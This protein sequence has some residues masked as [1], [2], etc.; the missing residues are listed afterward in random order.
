MPQSILTRR[1]EQFSP[2]ADLD[3]SQW[4]H[5]DNI[6]DSDPGTF[7]TSR[8]DL[9]ERYNKAAAA[10]GLQLANRQKQ[11]SIDLRDPT[12]QRINEAGD[13]NFDNGLLTSGTK[14]PLDDYATKVAAMRKF[15]LARAEGQAK[16]ANDE[17]AVFSPTHDRLRREHEEDLGTG[18][19]GKIQ[20]A[21]ARGA[22]KSDL[23]A[24]SRQMSEQAND[25]LPGID[26][27][28]KLGQELHD[29]GIFTPGIG[30]LRQAFA[31]HG[32]GSLMGMGPDVAGKIGNFNSEM[33]L[34]ISAIQR[35][36]AGARGAGN[37]AMAKR[38]EELLN[39]QGDIPTFLG[40]LGGAKNWMQQY[41]SHT[42]PD[43]QP[44]GGGAGRRV[45]RFTV[46]Q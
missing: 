3:P 10:R 29:L 7:P 1:G 6:L 15:G 45:G 43:V 25:V 12:Q 23:T 21:I 38:F 16:N 31:N 14:Q 36:H 13:L 4:A 8:D 24:S 9:F 2:S 18:I 40:A 19:E 27:V 20:E 35:A 44:P 11:Q 32:A 30:S 37:E 46:E 34:L 42:N 26:R 17:E 22:A 5:P 28:S 39:A 41:A 33:G